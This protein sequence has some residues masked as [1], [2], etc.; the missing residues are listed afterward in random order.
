M[1][2][3]LTLKA[4]AERKSGLEPATMSRI[5]NEQSQATLLIAVRMCAALD[6]TVEEVIK[7][8]LSGAMFHAVEQQPRLPSRY[9]PI[10]TAHEVKAFVAFYTRDIHRGRMSL[11]RLL[12]SVSNRT[13]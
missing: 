5:E 2:R 4:V 13:G 9:D 1:H 10:V 6:V 7:T 12:N 8:V 11:L 3:G